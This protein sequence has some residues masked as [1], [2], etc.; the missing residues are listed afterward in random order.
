MA[1][2]EKIR[3]INKFLKS[4]KDPHTEVIIASLLQDY[5]HIAAEVDI[6]SH[7]LEVKVPIITSLIQIVESQRA[8]V[9]T[10][11]ISRL[12]YLALLFVPLSFVSGLFSMNANI[13]PGGERLLD[14]FHSGYSN[15]S[16]GVL[17]CSSSY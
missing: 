4:V 9:E 15:M 3:F 12:T 17:C 8:L 1:T 5:E 7:S 6:Y 13:A 14:L 10:G 16:H 11:N 2:S